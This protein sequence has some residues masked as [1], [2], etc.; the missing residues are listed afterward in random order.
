MVMASK[1][2]LGRTAIP[3]RDWVM[4]PGETVSDYRVSRRKPAICAVVTLVTDSAT[5]A[6]G[7]YVAGLPNPLLA[8]GIVVI[9]L[10]IA[11]TYRR[12][13]TLSG[14]DVAPPVVLAAAVGA[15]LSTVIV[16]EGG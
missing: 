3:A 7:Y 6:A 16:G 8:S 15:V 11:G 10:A 4:T 13:L 14:L 9:C 5:I 2:V 1:P 12:R